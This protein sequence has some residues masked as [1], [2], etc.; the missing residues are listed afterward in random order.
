MKIISSVHRI[1]IQVS[2]RAN[3]TGQKQRLFTKS[4]TIFVDEKPK[5]SDIDDIVEEI[6]QNLKESLK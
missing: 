5:Q 3:S 4:L 6:R 1:C 2:Y